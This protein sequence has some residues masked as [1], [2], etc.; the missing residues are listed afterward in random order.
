VLALVTVFLPGCGYSHQPLYPDGIG[1]ISIPI[2]ENRTE[3]RDIEFDITEALIKEVELQTPY[4]AVRTGDADSVLRGSITAVEQRLQSRANV[5]GLPQEIEVTVLMDLK[6]TNAR[7]G[8]TIRDRKG[9][10][11]VVRYVPARPVSEPFSVAR[12]EVA[13]QTAREIVALMRKD[14]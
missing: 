10:A 1:N 9:M 4:K 5:G 13:Q 14:W 7:T 6:W 3:Y 12:H 11:V 8:T 2:F